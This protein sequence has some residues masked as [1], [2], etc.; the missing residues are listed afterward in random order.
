[1]LWVSCFCLN[2]PCAFIIG[3]WGLPEH[4]LPGAPEG[5]FCFPHSYHVHRLLVYESEGEESVR[6]CHLSGHSFCSM[7]L[8]RFICLFLNVFERQTE[9]F[10]IL[11]YSPNTLNVWSWAKSKRCDLGDIAQELQ[12]LKY[13]SHHLLPLK[14]ARHRELGPEAAP[15]MES[16]TLVWTVDIPTGL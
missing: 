14:G 3:W 1:M 15:D 16:R 6:V 7:D 11:A 8:R 10:H 12:G 5:A 13:L 2:F 9:T 4:L